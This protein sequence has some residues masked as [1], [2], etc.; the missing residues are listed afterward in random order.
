M[1]YHSPFRVGPHDEDVHPQ[2]CSSA[3]LLSDMSLRVPDLSAAPISTPCMPAHLLVVLVVDKRYFALRQW[4][5]VHAL[6]FIRTAYAARV[7]LRCWRTV[8]YLLS[9]TAVESPRH[10]TPRHAPPS[11]VPQDHRSLATTPLYQIISSA[12]SRYSIL[13][14]WHAKSSFHWRTRRSR[15]ASR[16]ND[17]GSS[18]MRTRQAGALSAT[19]AAGCYRAR[20]SSASSGSLGRSPARK[21]HGGA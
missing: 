9:C 17:F 7:A 12:A 14:A 20:S 5:L 4:Y 18:S 1:I 16:P 11:R 3:I 15:S 19:V 21:A 10:A 8:C 2:C 6:A 13:L